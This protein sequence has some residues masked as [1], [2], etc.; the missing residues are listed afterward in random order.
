MQKVSLYLDGHLWEA[1][2]IACLKAHITA[3]KQVGLLLVQFL[4]EQ[5][6]H[7]GKA[8]QAQKSA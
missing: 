6:C 2:R 4:H 7:G 5:E 3:S 8:A 1:F